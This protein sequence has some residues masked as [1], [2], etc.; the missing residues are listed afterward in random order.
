M[1]G[2]EG[3]PENPSVC[4]DGAARNVEIRGKK[5]NCFPRDQSLSDIAHGEETFRLQI[6]ENKYRERSTFAGNSAL[7]PTDVVDL[8]CCSLRDFGGKQSH[9]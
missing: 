1:P 3:F 2:P 8:Q 7:L 5:I 4:R 9:C 6:Y